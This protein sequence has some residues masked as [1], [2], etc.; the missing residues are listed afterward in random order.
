LWG[1]VHGTLNVPVVHRIVSTA[2]PIHQIPA[3]FTLLNAAAFI[4]T[5]QPRSQ[6]YRRRAPALQGGPLS[7]ILGNILL[8]E[9]DQKLERRG[10][11]LVRYADDCKSSCGTSLSA[12]RPFRRLWRP[13]PHAVGTV[14]LP[15]REISGVVAA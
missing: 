5:G 1:Q 7:P 10:H 13:Q 14:T 2:Q 4:V 6:S 15:F 8:D 12:L 11:Q 3:Q 9:W